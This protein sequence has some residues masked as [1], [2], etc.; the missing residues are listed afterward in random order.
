MTRRWCPSFC[1]D[2]PRWSRSGELPVPW[3][4]FPHQPSRRGS[5]ERSPHPVF[6]RFA[7]RPTRSSSWP[8]SSCRTTRSGR[9]EHAPKGQREGDWRRRC[10]GW[11]PPARASFPLLSR[12]AVIPLC[13][14]RQRRV[15]CCVHW[16]L[17]GAGSVRVSTYD[18]RAGRPLRGHV[19][20]LS[21]RAKVNE[22]NSSS[23]LL[24]SPH[25]HSYPR[26]RNFAGAV[27]ARPSVNRFQSAAGLTAGRARGGGKGRHEGQAAVGEARARAPSPNGPES[28]RA[29]CADSI[30]ARSRPQ[31]VESSGCRVDFNTR[32]PIDRCRCMHAKPSR[33]Q[34]TQAHRSLSV[35]ACIGPSYKRSVLG[36]CMHRPILQAFSTG[37]NTSH[38]PGPPPPRCPLPLP[39]R[40]RLL[41]SS[42]RGR[43]LSGLVGRLE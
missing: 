3:P 28:A 4:P 7:V 31:P 12:P 33:L 25:K 5:L 41:S 43:W 35:H 38:L 24:S 16:H 13:P 10:L 8:P 20:C 18:L 30:A 37:C 39:L 9:T 21:A 2:S 11:R 15:K 40:C 22:K 14:R 17:V 36:A 42:G 23:R 34:D 27:A 32:R 6:Q 26:Y 1:R 29:R 19:V